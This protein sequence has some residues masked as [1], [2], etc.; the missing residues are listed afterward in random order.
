MSESYKLKK[1]A[2]VNTADD[3]VDTSIAKE[4]AKIK[5][6]AKSPTHKDEEGNFKLFQLDKIKAHRV[7][8]EFL[9]E[10]TKNYPDEWIPEK[11]LNELA[12]EEA[13]DLKKNMESM[14][15]CVFKSIE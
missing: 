2:A 15:G 1:P 8:H 12:L 3:E 10:W 6:E 11:D 13:H 7:V 4:V 5:K 9:V 14:G